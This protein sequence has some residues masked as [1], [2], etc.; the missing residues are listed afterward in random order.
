MDDGEMHDTEA[1]NE[2]VGPRE[3][4]DAVRPS[5]RG[6]ALRVDAHLRAR[7]PNLVTRTFETSP[8]RFVIS[9]DRA[10]QDA[11]A[12]SKEFDEGIRLAG[13]GITLSNEAPQSFLAELP[14]LGDDEAAGT[15]AGLALSISD[16]D[17][18]VASRFPEFP[19]VGLREE[20]PYLRIVTERPLG[21]DAKE[22]L[23]AFVDSMRLPLVAR[24]AV[25][26]APEPGGPPV[27]GPPAADHGDALLIRPA[28]RRP[29][30]PAFVRADEAFWFEHLRDAAVG[31]MLPERF[32]GVVPDRFR[33]YVDLSVGEH[34]N[35]R[36]M[37][38]LYDQVLCSLP[39][40]EGH[41]AFLA[42]QGLS[43]A[44]LL[45]VI[46]SGRLTL[47]STQPEERLK[48]SFLE[49]AA[50][51]HPHA[52]LGRRTAA[53]LLVADVART[54]EGYRLADPNSYPALRELADGLA[55]AVGLS[56]ASMLRAL[57][58]PLAARRQSLS[59]LIDRGT[60]AGPGLE[61]AQILAEAVR[62][63]TKADLALEAI[64]VSER[65]QIGHALDATVF[66]ALDEPGA[67]TPL[68]AVL[69]RE[70]NFYR[71]F[72]TALA[73]AWVGNERRRAEGVQVMPPI[74]L[75]EFDPKVPIAE[76]LADS[77]LRSTRAKGRALFARLADLPAEARGAEIDALAARLRNAGRRRKDAVLSF[78]NLDTALSLGSLFASFVYP[79]VAGLAH[80]ARPLVERLRR[81]PSID[82]MVQAV[83]QDT[84]AAFGSN[85]DLDFL[86][87][88]D[89]VAQL[90]RAR[91]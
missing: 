46:A 33:C 29:R 26:P 38:L 71:S 16:I 14:P 58:W 18:L 4:P 28:R 72:N 70:L 22:S 51:C 8:E 40:A 43:E 34:V 66:G 10:L 60:K 21:D 55:P 68:M 56:P 35:L 2:A 27:L 37:L 19:I 84:V 20:V 23:T 32:P 31:L 12:I 50:E 81:V 39:L 64:V 41:D 74:P 90:R 76:V 86:S 49:A 79:P 82:R 63:A 75:F 54:A 36:Q 44:D 53:L 7:F 91:V 69:G 6:Y 87:R 59:R 73:A 62:S 88:I 67:V 83:E 48:L 24:F 9:F 25:E 45:Q 1:R 77:A 3:A 61:L 5:W 17:T 78:D 15:M 80:L 11:S 47:V 89:R 57:L 42:K 13:L 30:A 52:V 85:Q 65:V